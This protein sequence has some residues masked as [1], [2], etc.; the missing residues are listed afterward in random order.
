MQ[1]K[2]GIRLVGRERLPSEREVIAITMALPN[3]A[4]IL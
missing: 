4:T 3:P 1:P 2:D